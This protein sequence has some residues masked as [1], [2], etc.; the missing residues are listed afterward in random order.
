MILSVILA[1]L[2]RNA[3]T[4]LTFDPCCDVRLSIHQKMDDSM[5]LQDQAL[6]RATLNLQKWIHTEGRSF[7]SMRSM[8]P[9][10]AAQ[11]RHNHAVPVDRIFVGAP[12]VNPLVAAWVWIWEYPNLLIETD[13][14][15][16]YM[17]Q[18]RNVSGEDAPLIQLETKD[19]VRVQASDEHIPQ[20][21]QPM[22]Q[23]GGYVDL[24]GLRHIE[25]KGFGGGLTYA[26]KNK[27][28]FSEFHIRLFDA[29]MP[30]LSMLMQLFLTNLTM[31]S[32][33]QTYLGNDPGERVYHGS[34]RRGEGTTI[35]AVVWF[36]DMRDF[37]RLSGLLERDE[38][39]SLINEVFETTECILRNHGGEIL[40]FM[41]DGL[42][43]IF[44]TTGLTREEKFSICGQAR[45]AAAEVQ[46]RL[47]DLRR[48]RTEKGLQGT[49][50]GIGLHYG[51]VSY[52]NIGAQ[53]RM[54]FTVIGTAVNI[55]SRVE[56][57]CRELGASILATEEFVMR[58]EGH[59]GAW[60]SRGKVSLK[61]VSEKIQVFE[62][63]SLSLK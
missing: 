45:E 19:T 36:S 38:I 40:K 35:R 37:T 15:F 22:F 29:I 14:D 62:L 23:D 53:R 52:G 5:L 11:L 48:A 57:Q 13:R 49:Q 58:D 33:L 7:K 20:V 56:N 3:K 16:E 25:S 12:V 63:E 9:A 1:E 10:F 43:G 21:C 51:D 59:D 44:T 34:I 30:A 4:P 26:T 39:I 50:V 54:D 31:Y 61:G 60:K 8:L 55:A 18:R 24:Y 47:R 2:L 32:L 17:S 46:Q 27:E 42:L 41:G 28:G 6:L